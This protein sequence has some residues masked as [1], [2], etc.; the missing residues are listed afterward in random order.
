MI[1]AQGP[2]VFCGS[3]SPGR[4]FAQKQENL[5]TNI[6]EF[7]LTTSYGFYVEKSVNLRSNYSPVP[8]SE[9]IAAVLRKKSRFDL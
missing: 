5:K 6:F 8:L 9:F 4:F 1:K 3:K 7:E 2:K